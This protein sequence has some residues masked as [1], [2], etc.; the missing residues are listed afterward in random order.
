[1]E[2]PNLPLTCGIMLYCGGVTQE[3]MMPTDSYPSRNEEADVGWPS[4]NTRHILGLVALQFHMPVLAWKGELYLKARIAH[5][6]VEV[7]IKI[8][9]T[10]EGTLLAEQATE[11]ARAP[12]LPGACCGRRIWPVALG[13]AASNRGRELMQRNRGHVNGVTNMYG[14]TL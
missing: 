5:G 9:L 11:R 8:L 1:V 10:E 3:A 12:S 13:Q 6:H 7:A 4:T 2:G 14:A